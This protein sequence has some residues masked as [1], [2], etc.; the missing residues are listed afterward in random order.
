MLTSRRNK[1][2]KA[3]GGDEEEN[4]ISLGMVMPTINASTGKAKARKSEFK[5]TLVYI[6]SP[7]QSRVT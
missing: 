3:S 7:R 6:L 4:C 5:A 1:P 2:E